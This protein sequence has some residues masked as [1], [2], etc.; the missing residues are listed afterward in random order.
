MRIPLFLCLLLAPLALIQGQNIVDAQAATK[1][2]VVRVN[3][4]N[5]PH[6]FVRPWGKRPPFV[7][8]GIGAV[9]P[10]QRVLVTS[11][12]VANSNYI[13]FEAGDSGQKMPAIVEVVDY[14]AN[15]AL[16][17]P[18]DPAFLKGYSPLELTVATVGDTLGVWQLEANGNLLVT[19]GPMTSAE[20]TRYSIDD[21]SFLVYRMTASLQFRDSSFVLPVVKE[22]K[23]VGLVMRYDAQSNNAD[24]VPTPVIEHFLRDAAQMPYQGFPRAGMSF[25][26]TRDP[27]LRRFMGLPETAVGGVYITEVSKNSPSAKAGL[28]E[29]DVLLRID[30][31]PVDQDGNYADPVYGKIAVG[32]LLSVRHNVGDTVKFTIF[33]KGE[34]KDLPV[35]L[36]RRPLESYVSEP[37]VIDRAPKFYILGGL[38]LQELSRQYLKEWGNDWQRKAPDELVYLDRAQEEL[39]PEGGRKIVFLGRVLPSDATV[40]YEGLD[41]LIVTE[42]NDVPLRSLA[43]VPGALEKAQDGTHKIEFSSDPTVIYLNAQQVATSEEILAKTYRLPTLKRLE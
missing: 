22:D 39:F 4:T 12:L 6:D 18:E 25:S 26:G 13:E 19:R 34:T 33:R 36:A 3:V 38:V 17:K 11:E 43:D 9:L 15:L 7:R 32:H 41:H 28:E 21:S 20:V 42:I 29:G 35:E 30:D 27:Q 40:G 8:R 10:N 1:L 23:L 31:Q 2:S 24:I 16:L 37:Y 14:E 5:Q